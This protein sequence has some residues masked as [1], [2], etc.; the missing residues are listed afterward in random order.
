M[1]AACSDVFSG[2]EEGVPP[3]LSSA[4]SSAS[5]GDGDGDGVVAR[6]DSWLATIPIGRPGPAG[7]T[8]KRHYDAAPLAAFARRENLEHA[9]PAEIY[10]R[11]TEQQVAYGE[12]CAETERQLMA[13]EAAAAAQQQQQQQPTQGDLNN[14]KAHPFGAPQTPPSMQQERAAQAAAQQQQGVQPQQQQQGQQESPFR[15]GRG[16]MARTPP[17]GEGMG[18]RPRPS[19]QGGPPQGGPPGGGSGLPGSPLK[20]QA[21][22]MQ[23]APG[24]THPLEGV[25]GYQDLIDPEPIPPSLKSEA[26]ELADLF[27]EYVI[28]CFFSKTW[29]LREAALKKICLEFPRILN[30]TP[31]LDPLFASVAKMLQT[32]AGEKVANVFA[33][34]LD[35]LNAVLT[36][37]APHLHRAEVIQGLER[38]TQALVE[39]LG[40]SNARVRKDADTALQSMAG[41]K[42]IGPGYIAVTMLR[43]P[44]KE[45][46][47]AYRPILG[48]LQVRNIRYFVVVVVVVVGGGGGALGCFPPRPR[49]MS[50]TGYRFSFP[51][52]HN[53]PSCTHPPSRYSCPSS[54]CMVFS[55]ICRWIRSCCICSSATHLSTARTRSVTWRG[56]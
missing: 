52:P 36:G 49:T 28:K 37:V 21:P 5:G 30:S 25:E 1:S 53:T 55:A 47:T 38:Y 27:G 19:G 14:V 40:N 44:K 41:T 9:P 8:S 32:C 13:A 42:T 56:K 26:Q 3:P 50:D 51:F 23:L 29:Q 31:Q 33:R 48:R 7:A 39:K 10:R 35:F 16:G 45:R 46:A 43:K 20:R 18:R 34:S 4:S 54:K 15:P 22:P 12:A 2:A 6:L 24:Q 17:A 11:Y